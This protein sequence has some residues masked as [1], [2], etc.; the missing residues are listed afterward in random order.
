M[1]SGDRLEA[2]AFP[3]TYLRKLREHKPALCDANVNGWL[4]GD[5]RRFLLRCSAWRNGAGV[6]RAFLSDGYKIID[7]LDVLLAAL[8]GVRQSGF[9]V[10][11]AR[12][13][14]PRPRLD[15]VRL[16]RRRYG[17]LRQWEARNV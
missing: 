17:K 8:D 4:D 16:A 7:S 6:A 1:R 14:R 2:S 13:A 15:R 11:V 12:L 5:D 9:A 10:Q 3:G